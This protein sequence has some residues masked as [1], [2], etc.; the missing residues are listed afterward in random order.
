MPLGELMRIPGRKSMAN[1]L[2][3]DLILRHGRDDLVMHQQTIDEER[4]VARGVR[5]LEFNGLAALRILNASKQSRLEQLPFMSE[6]LH[7]RPRAYRCLVGAEVFGALA[8]LD[9]SPATRQLF[10]HLNLQLPHATFAEWV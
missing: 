5:G 9:H 1:R 10:L 2:L 8:Q 3:A 7:R 4:L 6:F